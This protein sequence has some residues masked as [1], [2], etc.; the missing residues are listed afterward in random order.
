LRRRMARIS[1]FFSIAC[2]RRQKFRQL[3]NNIDVRNRLQLA[4]PNVPGDTL[5]EIQPVP[6]WSEGPST[7]F[8]VIPDD[9]GRSI[10]ERREF[11]SRPEPLAARGG[12]LPGRP[13]GPA[14]SGREVPGRPG[15]AFPAGRDLLGSPEPAVPGE[16]GLWNRPEEPS[17]RFR[18][19][20]GSPEETSHMVSRTFEPSRTSHSPRIRLKCMISRSCSRSFDL[21][22][23]KNFH[24]CFCRFQ[25]Y[26]GKV[27]KQA[28]GHPSPRGLASKP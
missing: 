24:C 1:R 5:S 18:D 23:E 17:T 10:H 20:P 6:A 27:Q 7:K 22:L 12:R 16:R 13:K 11:S 28:S 21:G 19:L 15:G 8:R 9:A 3:R 25:S 26:S 4:L 14:T 2:S